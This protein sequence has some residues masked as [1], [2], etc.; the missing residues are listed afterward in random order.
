MRTRNK[1]NTKQIHTFTK[2]GV[3]SDGGG[4]YLRVRTAGTRSWLF[5]RVVNG[6]RRELGLGSALDVTL[7]EARDEASKLRKTFRDGKDPAHVRQAEQCANAKAK[8]FGEFAEP[9]MERIVQ[10]YRNDKHRAQ[11]LS[12]VRTY[13]AS[14]Y[15]MPL[16]DI[17]ARDVVAVL[18]PIWLAKPETASRVRQRLERILDAAKVEGLRDGDN[19]ARLKGHLDVLLPRQ[20]ASKS[21]HAALPFRELPTLMAQ[22]RKRNGTAARALE[23]T[24]LTAARTGEVLGM[25]WAEIDLEQKLWT[26]P[27]ERMKAGEAHEVPLSEA[28]LAILAAQAPAKSDPTRLVFHNGKGTQLSNMAMTQVL[29]RMERGDITV[30]GFRSTFRDWAGEATEFAREDGAGASGG[31]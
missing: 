14:L 24:I 11:W 15:G 29:R 22:L 17:D 19:P 8:T 12:T 1:L 9:F 21:H 16:R 18:Q 3:Y 13:A 6:K 10:V 5:V 28:A 25:K 27:A 31:E 20:K 7:A 26:V 30:H 4:L 23:F 2:P